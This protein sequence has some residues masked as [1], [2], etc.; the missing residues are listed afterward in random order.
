MRV[1]ENS[2]PLELDSADYPRSIRDVEF[3][4]FPVIPDFAIELRE[5]DDYGQHV[6]YVSASAGS[7]ALRV[8]RCAQIPHLNGS[9]Q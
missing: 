3:G 2:E 7:P 4:A 6:H 5:S 8:G 9:V 1:F